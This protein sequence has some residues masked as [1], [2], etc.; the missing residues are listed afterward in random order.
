MNNV[1]AKLGN[2]P[3]TSSIIESL[4]PQ[5]KGGNQKIRQREKSGDIIRLKRGGG[6]RAAPAR[7]CRPEGEPGGDDPEAV[8]PDERGRAVKKSNK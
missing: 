8:V 4:Y 1:L 6:E 5:I 7:E 2:I 3:V